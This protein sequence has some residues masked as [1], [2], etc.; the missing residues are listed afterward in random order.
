MRRG[1]TMIEM[2]FVIVI[3]GI[4]ASVA[5]PR[6][7]ATRDDA[8]DAR[9]CKN[10]STCITDLMADYTARGETK[11]T[12]SLSCVRVQNSRKNSVSLTINN[13]DLNVSGAPETCRGL[14]GGY[15]LGGTRIKL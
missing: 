1:F 11:I 3:V 6:L 7:S 15:R 9:D 13:K 5:I 2:I 4:L 8:A 14:N 12:N 10:L